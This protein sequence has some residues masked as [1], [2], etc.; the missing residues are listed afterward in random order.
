IFHACACFDTFQLLARVEGSRSNFGIIGG[1]KAQKSR[2]KV[3]SNSE[4]QASRKQP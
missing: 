3:R 1:K 4:V 2:R